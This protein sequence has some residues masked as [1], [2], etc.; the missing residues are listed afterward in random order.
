MGDVPAAPAWRAL[1][2]RWR[3]HWQR[4]HPRLPPGGWPCG[5]RHPGQLPPRARLSHAAQPTLTPALVAAAG[6]Y[7]IKQGQSFLSACACHILPSCTSHSD[8]GSLEVAYR[9]AHSNCPP[10]TLH[11]R[12]PATIG[13]H[14]SMRRQ[15][16]SQ[17][18]ADGPDSAHSGFPAR[19]VDGL[20]RR[21][22]TPRQR[23]Q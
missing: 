21:G 13:Q 19:R 6:P 15:D 7:M 11:R 1:L 23:L 9:V 3:Q 8:Q 4:L 5:H 14:I 20:F 17:N 22:H 10:D 18:L 16:R 2:Q 12:I